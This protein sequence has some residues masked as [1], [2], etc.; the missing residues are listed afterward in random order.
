MS[1]GG[2]TPTIIVLK[3]GTDTSQG[4]GQILSNIN[5]CL[6]VQATIKSTL[7]PYGGDLLM[8]DANG[9][10]TIT[11][12]G[13][14]VMKLLDIVHPAARILVDIARSQDAE[15]GDGTTSVVVLAGEILKEIKEHVESGVSSQ[16]IIK[17]LRRACAMAVNKIKEIQVS[18]TEANRR[19]TLHKLAATAMTSKLIKR[20]TDFFT[21]MVVDA[22]LSLDQDD[23][24]E[25]LIGIKKIPGGSLTDSLF[26]NGVAFKKT[27]SYAGF[28]QQPKAFTKPKVLCLNVELELKAEKDN[29]E[30]RVEQ[31]SEYQAI[32]DAEWQII[33]KKLEAAYQS[34]A[35][36]VLSKLPIGDLATQYFADRDIFCAGRVSS[37]DMERVVQ[38]TG[39]TIQSTCS[40]IRPEHLGT[41]GRFEERQIGGERYNFF[42]DCP[43]AK[44][45]TLVLRGG[46]EQFIAEVE[47]SLHDA[48][49]I[50]K[51]AIRNKTIVAGGGATEMEVSAYLHRFA[52]QD[53]RN[54][55][56]AVVKSFAKALEIIPRQ[57]C[58]N[59]GF[60]A[61]DILNRLRVEH[62]RGNTW[63][64]VDFQNEG[65][66]DMMERFVWE[67]A[68]VKINAIQAAT[69][70]A[71]LILGVDETIRNEESKTPQ[72]PGK[73]LPPG[74]AQRA[75]RGRGRGMP[76]R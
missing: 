34:G 29:A 43:Q 14:T 31:V 72:P 17:G 49:M 64:G 75:L 15:V 48:I 58:D 46:A 65:V 7:G 52:D 26:V 1:F 36:V 69:E 22:V 53:V 50:V 60:D 10:Q 66:A 4:K 37:E 70:A 39:A 76:R 67:P 63:A 74:A 24:N 42:E 20:N 51:R 35:K 71:C 61:T 47:R 57:L 40:D 55:Q 73:P 12:D 45:C 23:L 59:A 18:T 62:R 56:Q 3:E 13:A 5:A 44:T 16:I 2:Q 54:K 9:K 6:A 41:C 21:K 8:V 25:K 38:A 27:F 32:V 68:L 33:Y 30:V 28:E 19:D 11:N